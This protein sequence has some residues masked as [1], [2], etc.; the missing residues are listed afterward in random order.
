MFRSRRSTS[1]GVRATSKLTAPCSARRL[2]WRRSSFSFFAPSASRSIS[3]ASPVASRQAR[4]C[5]CST[6][7]LH[8]AATQHVGK[9]LHGRAIKRGGAED[10]RMRAGLPGL[11][12]NA[13]DG[14]LRHVAVEQRRA[15]RAVGIGADQSGQRD[16]VGAP[17]RD[18]RHQADQGWKHRATRRARRCR[19]GPAPKRSPPI[20]IRANNSRSARRRASDS[21]RHWAAEM[22]ASGVSAPP[23]PGACAFASL[24]D[25][26]R[27]VDVSAISATSP[28]PRSRFMWP[29][30]P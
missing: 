15:K 8:A 5:D 21:A 25:A 6:S 2:R 16:L 13:G 27:T 17:H 19:R 3:S 12:Q 4:T 1:A 23:E 14:F 22:P 28:N 26:R 20:P 30:A 18:H 10:Q 24:L 11:L 9:G 7:G 29:A